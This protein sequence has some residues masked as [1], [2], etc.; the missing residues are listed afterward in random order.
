MVAQK[1]EAY[2]KEVEEERAREAELEQLAES[3]HKQD[4]ACWVL[5][6]GTFS[7]HLATVSLHLASI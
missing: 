4:P 5:L 1:G 6:I 7:L 3:R 2:K